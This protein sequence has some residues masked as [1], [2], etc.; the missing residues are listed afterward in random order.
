M[1][2]R[3]L[4]LEYAQKVATTALNTV[5]NCMLTLQALMYIEENDLTGRPIWN[6]TTGILT[7]WKGC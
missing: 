7:F 1:N 4:P 3:D 5:L 2:K 6:Y